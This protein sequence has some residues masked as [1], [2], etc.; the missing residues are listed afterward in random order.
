MSDYKKAERKFKGPMKNV[1]IES[2]GFT[3]EKLEDYE[4]ASK[5]YLKILSDKNESS[6]INLIRSLRGEGKDDEA[7][8]YSEKFMELFP[9]SSYT[10]I[11]KAKMGKVPEKTENLKEGEEEDE[12]EGEE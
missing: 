8:K 7:D 11:V 4:E 1:V 2:I 10:E 6:Y 5:A 9:D 12:K 3:Q